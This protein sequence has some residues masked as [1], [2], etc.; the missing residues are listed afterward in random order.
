MSPREGRIDNG[1][2][3][4]DGETSDNKSGEDDD[5]PELWDFGHMHME[6]DEDTD[7]E[8]PGRREINEA[9]RMLEEEQNNIIGNNQE[10]EIIF[11]DHNNNNN[12]HNDNN[13]NNEENNDNENYD[14]HENNNDQDN[15]M[16]RTTNRQNISNDNRQHYNRNTE[17]NNNNTQATENNSSSGVRQGNAENPTSGYE[18]IM[19]RQQRKDKIVTNNEYTVQE[20]V[21]FIN[22]Q[23]SHLTNKH[24]E[25]KQKPRKTRR[26]KR[27]VRNPPTRTKQI[28]RT[29]QHQLR[30]E[31]LNDKIVSQKRSIKMMQHWG[32]QIRIQTNWPTNN[33]N[34]TLRIAAVNING[35]SPNNKYLELEAILGQM[36]ENQIDILCLT[37]INLDVHNSQV[38]SDVWDTLKKLDR[39]IDINMKTSKHKSRITN[40]TF[41]P[42]GTMILTSSAWSGRRIRD[43]KEPKTSDKFGRWTTTHLRGQKGKIVSIIN[44]YRVSDD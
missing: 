39:H 14:N 34:N 1:A 5:M 32:N 23:F 11:L 12:S 21:D 16:A 6:D 15:T 7:D 9:T 38:Y 2:A 26:T 8:S 24:N 20:Q 3:Y 30:F 18:R 28:K 44:W 4:P 42:G 37:E 10:E 27:S 19:N 35:I 33:N 41:K 13:D 25:N 36:V 17:V 40:S 31:T 29:K 43:F 22:S